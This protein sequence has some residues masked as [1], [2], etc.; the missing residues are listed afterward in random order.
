MNDF[1]EQHF[2]LR[3]NQTSVRTELVAGLTTFLT[4]AYIIF[5][6]PAV[7]SGAMF[8]RPTGME[9]GA[10]TTATCLSAALA[11]AIMALYAR[12]P[13]AQAPGMGE[14]FFF[15]FGAIP[16]AAAAGFTNAWQV[17]L[18]V[19]FV[20]GVLFLVL[21]LFRVRETLLDALS[22]S[23][24]NGIAVGI[25]LFIAFI[26]L[27]NAGLI[28]K[29]PATGVTLNHHFGSPDLIIFFVGLFVA[30][31]LHA[32]QVRGAILWG[33]ASATLLAIVFK[34][35][36]P[37]LPDGIAMSKEVTE[38]L[39][40][41]RFA[42]ADKLVAAPPSLAPT[43]LQMDL[44]GALSLAMLPFVIVFLFMVLF[45][46]VGTL[47]GVGEQAGF[48]RDNRLPRAK[49]AFVADAL[50]TTAGACLG[51]ST[52]T[53]YLESATGVA[54]GGRTGLTSLATAALFLLALFFSPVI[55]MVGGYAPLTAPALVLVGA[56]M[57]RNVS[58]IDWEDPTESV[59]AFLTVLGIPLAYSIADGLALGFISYS[60]IKLL[61]GKGRSVHWILH[62]L[63]ALLVIYFVAVR[64]RLG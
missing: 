20:S 12:Y 10:V 27:Q 21:S 7:L 53:S 34:L 2:R 54:A 40:V 26:G 31:A 57:L 49:E 3:E 43:F 44:R 23:M 46:T 58:K 18:G 17:A 60:V 9:F 4:M 35:A 28:V 51:T 6:Q 47:V 33:I 32:R 41:K 36:L 25:G 14:N 45:D 1:L 24:K 8:G 22:P 38:S 13:I 42:L 29:S 62:L 16:A 50:G 5:V 19:V 37:S 52:V 56:M 48:I 55:A 63:A 64:A 61:T 59:P 39:L 11:S 30:A 15:V